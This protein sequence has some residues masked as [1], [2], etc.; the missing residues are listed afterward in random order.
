MRFDQFV[1]FRS[2][3]F[4]DFLSL[5]STVFDGEQQIGHSE[6]ID[7]EEQIGTG[8]R[9]DN[10]EEIGP[11]SEWRT[12]RGSGT[13]PNRWR[14]KSQDEPMPPVCDILLKVTKTDGEE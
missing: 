11:V 8:D 13:S 5:F 12:E 6:W 4:I 9:I 2:S 1:L 10:E 7:D 14:T 3:S